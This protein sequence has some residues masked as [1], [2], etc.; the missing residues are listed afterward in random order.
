VALGCR[1]RAVEEPVAPRKTI[2][3]TTIRTPPPSPQPADPA[4][5]P[6][7]GPASPKPTMSAPPT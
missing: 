3:Q 1:D 2:Q 5:R 6:A 4:A 7:S